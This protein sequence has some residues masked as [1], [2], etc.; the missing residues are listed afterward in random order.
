MRD[1]PPGPLLVPDVGAFVRWLS[2]GTDSVSLAEA[3]G[4]V[5][6]AGAPSGDNLHVLDYPVVQPGR[7]SLS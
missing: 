1:I 2:P 3:L 5:E 6:V 7:S 4:T